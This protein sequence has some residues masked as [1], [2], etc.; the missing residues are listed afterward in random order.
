LQVPSTQVCEEKSKTAKAPL[1]GSYYET[2][3]KRL[4]R[5]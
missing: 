2:Q 3:V 4:W 5:L 1:V